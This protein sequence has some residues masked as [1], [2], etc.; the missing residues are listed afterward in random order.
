VTTGVAPE[1][2]LLG[3]VAVLI[4]NHDTSTVLEQ[5]LRTLEVGMTSRLET[6]V[7]DNA[8]HDGSVDMMRTSF[9][10]VQVVEAGGNRGFG[11]GV[12][13]AALHTQ[14]RFLLILNPDC[15]IDPTSVARLAERLDGDPHIGFVGPRIDLASGAVDHASL[16]ADPDP[17]GALLYFSRIPR[18]FPYR[19]ALNRY[20]LAHLDYDAEQELLAGTAACLMVRAEAFANVGGF[21]ESF[22]MYGEDLD[23]CRR[24]REA[25]F[26]GRYVP[27]SRA[28]HLKGEASRTQSRRMLVEFHRAMWTYY[29]K[30]EKPRR[31]TAINWVVGA[32]IVALAGVRLATNTL[33][34]EKRVSAR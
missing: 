6:V 21:D 22:F 26:G 1:L 33:R 25:G 14:R 28:L 34:R 3:E 30:Y 11:A 31:P 18:L 24:L 7:V 27:A 29:Q 4:V 19:A 16:R 10:A 2:N 8:S 15:F 9:A 20:S 17:L 32:G 12:N 13:L 5:C 23:L